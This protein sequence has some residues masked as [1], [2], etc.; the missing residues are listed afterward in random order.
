MST[1][2][3]LGILGLSLFL[4]ALT[5]GADFGVGI[6]E[7]C[8]KRPTR[9]AIRQAGERAIAPIWEANHV[10][11]IVALVILFVGFPTIH[12]GLMV[13]LH[14]PIVLMLTGIIL[15]GTAFTFRY[16]DPSTRDDRV[17]SALFRTG[18]VI[19]PFSFGLIVGSVSAG[20]LTLEPQDAWTAWFGGWVHPFAFAVGAFM[21]TVFAWLA[22]VFLAAEAPSNEH[23]RWSQAIRIWTAVMF[24]AGGIVTLVG[25][26]S[27]IPWLQHPASNPWMVGSVVVATGWVSLLWV[28]LKHAGPWELRTFA[29]LVLGA[30]MLGYFGA[31]FPTALVWSDGQSLQWTDA[32]APKVVM[33]I[34]ALGLIIAAAI[35]LPALA[36]L[37]RIFKTV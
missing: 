2:I 1:I 17:W 24:V 33:D 16:Y 9:Q 14:V 35:V 32:A 3:V 20:H 12:T 25:L 19:V 8:A 27:N 23:I 36:W 7:L 31:H 26:A 13:S 21:L 6:L 18:S 10:W 22:A 15:R 28:R 29:G 5:G 4:Y 11:L 30:L 37:Y 34:L